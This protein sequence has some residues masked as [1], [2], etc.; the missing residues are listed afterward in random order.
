MNKSYP[1]F[2][3]FSLPS[4]RYLEAGS[5]HYLGIIQTH[6]VVPLASAAN[7]CHIIPLTFPPHFLQIIKTIDA[8][9][10]NMYGK[11]NALTVIFT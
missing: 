9:L 3:Y 6:L 10:A 11:K 2:M 5:E 7:R 4:I 8:I 1:G